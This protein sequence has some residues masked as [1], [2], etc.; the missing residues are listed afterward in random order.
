VKCGAAR[1]NTSSLACA[2]QKKYKR[3][4]RNEEIV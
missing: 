4:K 2:A 3:K 1:I